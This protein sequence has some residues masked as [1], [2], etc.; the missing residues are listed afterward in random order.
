MNNWNRT[1]T[2]ESPPMTGR[3]FNEL[4][5]CK[6]SH[7]ANSRNVKYTSSATAS[8]ATQ[9]LETYRKATP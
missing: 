4:Y 3:M 1:P 6:D 7:H 5:L 8:Q 9:Y 2:V